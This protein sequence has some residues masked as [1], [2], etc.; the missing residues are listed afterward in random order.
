VSRGERASTFRWPSRENI[1]WIPTDFGCSVV[2]VS[3]ATGRQY[4]IYTNT[5]VKVTQKLN[6]M[7]P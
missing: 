7:M 1:C 5:S 4:K 3:T 2:N 6:G